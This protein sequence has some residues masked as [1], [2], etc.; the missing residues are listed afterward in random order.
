MNKSYDLACTVVVAVARSL[1]MMFIISTTIG[2]CRICN[3]IYI[4][5]NQWCN[6][7]KNKILIT[8]T[9][10]KLSEWMYIGVYDKYKR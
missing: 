8:H 10:A 1:A 3:K 6:E 2:K 7:C 4:I 5:L 9:H